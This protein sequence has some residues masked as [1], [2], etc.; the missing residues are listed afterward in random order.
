MIHIYKRTQRCL[1]EVCRWRIFPF[2]RRIPT[3]SYFIQS[4]RIKG[5]YYWDVTCIQEGVTTFLCKINP[6]SH[7]SFYLKMT[8]YLLIQES[9]TSFKISFSWPRVFAR[10]ELNW[11]FRKITKQQANYQKIGSYKVWG[12]SNG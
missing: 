7:H 8:S 2:L 5:I 3:L 12:W 4:S 6:Q 10:N 11:S 1:Q 9:S